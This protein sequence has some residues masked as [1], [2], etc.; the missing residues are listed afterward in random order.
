MKPMERYENELQKN[1]EKRIETILIAAKRLFAEKGI[2]NTT[3]Q[4]VADEA[5]L[6]VATV[7]RM[8]SKKEKVA[9]AIASQGLEEIL[10]VFERAARMKCTCL[11]KI[12]V[13]LDHFVD[14]LQNEEA[15]YIKI[16]EDFDMYSTRIKEPLEDIQQFNTVY[17]KVSQTF[18]SIIEAGKR[19]GS[20]R[21]NINVDAT[22]V[23]LINTFAVF[24]KKLAIQ[25]SIFF[26]Q[27]DL[28]PEKQLLL[29]RQIILD[30][31]TGK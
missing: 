19:D 24:A 15:D 8:F 26:I 17:R 5:G 13:L 9:V 6:G 29:L 4:D 30:Y 21:A 23:T 3:M 11:E 22:L 10:K 12:E 7:F 14:E 18:S 20:I 28:E 27:L 31:L 25:K 2:E 1:R 16:L